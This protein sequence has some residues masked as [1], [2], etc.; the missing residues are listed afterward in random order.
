MVLKSHKVYLSNSKTVWMSEVITSQSLEN[1]LGKFHFGADGGELVS[2]VKKLPRGWNT[3][4]GHKFG[5]IDDTVVI[6]I[7]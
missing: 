2:S 7:T 3:K 1:G 4:W 5:E 6:S